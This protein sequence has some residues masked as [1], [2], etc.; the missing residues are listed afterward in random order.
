LGKGSSEFLFNII[1]PIYGLFYYR[2]RKRFSEV[3]KRIKKELDLTS[4]ETIIDVGCGTGALCS[5]LFE[6]GLSVTGIDP[7]EKMLKIAMNKLENKGITFVLANVLEKLPFDDNCFDI[8]IASYVAHG[9]GQNERKLLYTEMSRVTRSKVII[10]DYNENRSLLT[11]IIE[12][13]ERGDY[14]HFIKNAESEMKTC[15]SEMKACFS[16]VK[17][18]NVDVRAAWYICTPV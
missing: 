12:W 6:K 10:Y 9:M 2:Q 5:V 7:A 8:S 4:Y 13:L 1:A 18:V 15:V 14:F 17:V 16:E 11:T 3:L